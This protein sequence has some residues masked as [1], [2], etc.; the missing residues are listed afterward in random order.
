MGGGTLPVT[1]PVSMPNWLLNSVTTTVMV[2][3]C[4]PVKTSAIK[5][6]RDND[7][8]YR[9]HLRPQYAN[10]EVWSAGEWNPGKSIKATIVPNEWCDLGVI[11]QY[12]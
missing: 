5:I 10:H 9:E 8:D 1:P 12:R 3:A 11:T 2:V 4:D 6:Q 7:D